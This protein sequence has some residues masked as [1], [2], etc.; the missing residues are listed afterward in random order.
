GEI[1]G[2]V[3]RALTESRQLGTTS[4]ELE[5]LF[6]RASEAQRGV[7]NHT[8]IG[9]AGRS[10]VRLGLELADSRI[11]DWSTLRVLLVGTGA[12][13]AA[14]VAAGNHQENGASSPQSA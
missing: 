1:A 2:Q 14:T 8:A 10:L 6:Q 4:A 3:R 13:A 9:R 11:A 12:Y 5:R 7:K